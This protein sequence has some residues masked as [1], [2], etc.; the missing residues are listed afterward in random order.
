MARATDYVRGYLPIEEH[1]MVGDLHTIALVGTNATIDWY[2]CP[3]FD[4]PS[5]F[6]RILDSEKGGFYRLRPTGD[7]W[8]SKQL[9][10]PDTN[11]LI[12]RFFTPHGVGEIQDFMPIQAAHPF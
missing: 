12:T 11:V 9:Y 10:L 2:C 5:V 8:S 7:E 3:S 4:S 6:G 1:G